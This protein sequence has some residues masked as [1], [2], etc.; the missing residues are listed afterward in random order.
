MP[1]QHVELTRRI[2]MN[3]LPL[4]SFGGPSARHMVESI[5]FYELGPFVVL[6]SVN[7]GDLLRSLIVVSMLFVVW[8][9]ALARLR[10]TLAAR[11]SSTYTYPSFKNARASTFRIATSSLPLVN[12]LDVQDS[13]AGRLPLAND[14]STR[15]F[16]F[17]VPSSKQGGSNTLTIWLSG[18][19]VSGRI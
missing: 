5:V 7:P 15:Y 10:R 18:G 4:F 3:Y 9:L 11:S 13:W 17:Y 14:A 2:H 1:V 6:A 12:E 19:P 8:I 16:F